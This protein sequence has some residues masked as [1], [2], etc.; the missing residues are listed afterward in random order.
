MDSV[1]F[2]TLYAPDGSSLAENYETYRRTTCGITQRVFFGEDYFKLRPSVMTICQ[3]GLMFGFSGE[4][5][6]LLQVTTA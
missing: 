5:F 4:H 6:F 2:R 1:T 3:R